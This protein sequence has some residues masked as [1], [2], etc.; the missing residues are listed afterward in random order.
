MEKPCSLESDFNEAALERG[1][2]RFMTT[3]P[4][5]NEV[6]VYG[7]SGVATDSQSIY[8]RLS[9]KS[10]LLITKCRVYKGSELFF[11]S[12]DPMEGQAASSRV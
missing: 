9:A 1:N 5:P 10:I 8:N 6:H 2:D 3:P 4:V 7:D 11:K 12:C